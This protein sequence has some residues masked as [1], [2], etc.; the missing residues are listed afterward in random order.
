M[1]WAVSWS[2]PEIINT[3]FLVVATLMVGSVPI[4][5][6][7]KANL[8]DPFARAVLAGTG[9]TAFAFTATLV[10]LIAYHAGF[11]PPGPIWNWI[12]RL[13]YAAVAFGEFML[14][15]GLLRVLREARHEVS[16]NRMR[17]SLDE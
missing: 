2:A 13:T 5:Y 3:M 12:A 9:A 15:L 16:G 6:F 11:N 14:L 17:E 8:R 1:D 10:A 7:I 4:V